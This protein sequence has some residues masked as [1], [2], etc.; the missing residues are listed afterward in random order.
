MKNVPNHQ[1]GKFV[2]QVPPS[3]ALPDV[4]IPCSPHVSKVLQVAQVGPAPW[5]PEM[6]C[7]IIKYQHVWF[8]LEKI[9]YGVIPYILC[10]PHDFLCWSSRN[11]KMN[12]SMLVLDWLTGWAGENPPDMLASFTK[13]P[14]DRPEKLIVSRLG[15]SNCLAPPWPSYYLQGSWE[16]TSESAAISNWISWDRLKGKMM[17]PRSSM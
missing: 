6:G 7:Q 17:W 9:R 8:Q 15:V 12:Q 10:K 16:T 11:K 3:T 4:P 5:N 14:T 2:T 13:K 1:P